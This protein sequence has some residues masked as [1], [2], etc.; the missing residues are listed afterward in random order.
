M[1]A[2]RR[3]R[4]RN[5]GFAMSTNPKQPNDSKADGPIEYLGVCLCWVLYLAIGAALLLVAVA[6][7]TWAWRVVFG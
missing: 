3:L 1:T 2:V 7:L 6:V 4:R 5:R